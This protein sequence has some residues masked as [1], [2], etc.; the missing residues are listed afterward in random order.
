MKDV[1]IIWAYLWWTS[2]CTN[3]KLALQWDACRNHLPVLKQVIS[4]WQFR[5]KPS[6]LN[7]LFLLECLTLNP[8]LLTQYRTFHTLAMVPW[9]CGNSHPRYNELRRIEQTLNSPGE[10]KMKSW[11]GEDLIFLASTKQQITCLF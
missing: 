10:N 3:F 4:N 7:N 5:F 2:S 6:K 8:Y 9:K 1:V 11:P